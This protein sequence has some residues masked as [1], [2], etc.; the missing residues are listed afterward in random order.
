MRKTAALLFSCFFAVACASPMAPQLPIPPAESAFLDTLQQRTFNFFW[1]RANPA[2]GLIP[3][4][5]PTP[6]FSSVAA[7]GFGLATYPVGIERGW[8]TRAQGA[9]R[10][11]TTLRFI[12]QAPQGSQPSGVIG[13][14][15]LFYHFLDMNTGH[16]FER[17]ELSTI[18]TGLLMAGVLF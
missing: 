9:Q 14:Q 7:V 17:V 3:D 10:T 13:H 16:R 5:W 18:D 15:G 2:N 12:W 4:R 6:S 8:I 11:L 1:E